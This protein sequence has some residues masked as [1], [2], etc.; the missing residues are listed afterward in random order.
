M[1]KENEQVETAKTEKIE[2]KKTVDI[3]PDLNL[4]EIKKSISETVKTEVEKAKAEIN[5]VD[6]SKEK[7]INVGVEDKNEKY[8]EVQKWFFET[9]NKNWNEKGLIEGSSSTGSTVQVPEE[10]NK[11]ILRQMDET[12]VVRRNATK[13]PMESQ[14]LDVT[15]TATEPVGKWV[16]QSSRAD[17]TGASYD[18]VSFNRTRLEC[19]GIISNP[20]LQDSPS[21]MVKH[22]SEVGASAIRKAEDYAVFSSTGILEADT[23]ANEVELTGILASMT[24]QKVLDLVNAG[25]YERSNGEKFYMHRNT[26][27]HVQGLEDSNGNIVAGVDDVK[28]P[29]WK[30]IGVEMCND[31]IDPLT[32]DAT[33]ITYI[34]FTDLSKSVGLGVRNDEQVAVKS[35]DVGY[36]DSVSLFDT[37]QTAVRYMVDEDVKIVRPKYVSKLVSV[38]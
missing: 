17:G 29:N 9:K 26:W 32:A 34:W 7:K 16:G 19:K 12:G 2:E 28:N 35:T 14:Q 27:S 11:E 8:K 38:S 31:M 10:L 37:D 33:G 25:T 22:L 4:E 1:A 20:L 23:S 21:D 6:P 30:G 13:Y 5:K 36:V 3:V 15:I 24:Y 18:T